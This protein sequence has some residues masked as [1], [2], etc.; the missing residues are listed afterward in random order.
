MKTSYA[1]GAALF[2]AFLLFPLASHAADDETPVA[3]KD[4]PRHRPKLQND[5]VRVL[6][7]EIPPSY[8]TLYH[9]HSVDYAYLMINT[10]SLKNEIPGQAM[11]DIQVKAGDVGYYRSSRGAYTHRFT[12]VSQAM[13][14][15]IGIELMRPPGTGTVA[16][17]LPESTGYF[18][19][20]DTERVRAYRVSLEPGQSSAMVTIAGPSVRVFG[21]T[22]KLRDERAGGSASV[23]AQPAAFE[24]RNE[25][26]STKLTNIGAQRVDVYEFE[27]K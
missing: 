6:D 13:F 22:G 14:R 20:L 3:A 12:N 24:Y 8:R 5:V 23:D 1:L 4:E 15:A 18:T 26:V 9:T 27:I 17:P 7:V 2:A 10:V 25:A 21:T 19:V 11:S 16:A